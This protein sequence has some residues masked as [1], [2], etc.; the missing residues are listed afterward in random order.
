MTVRIGDVLSRDE[1]YSEMSKLNSE[2][3]V[4]HVFNLLHDNFGSSTVR[5][6]Q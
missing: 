2:K 5:D 3:E 4:N 6:W 1:E